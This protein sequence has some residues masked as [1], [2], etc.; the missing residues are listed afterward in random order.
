M[1]VPAEL[2]T[3][4]RQPGPITSRDILICN[5]SFVLLASTG[6]DRTWFAYKDHEAKGRSMS[7]GTGT[8]QDMQC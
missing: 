4:R 7:C 2:T 1:I 5:R 8:G 3:F 6:F